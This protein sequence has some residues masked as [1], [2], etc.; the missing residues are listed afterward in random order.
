MERL[1]IRDTK[2]PPTSFEH[3]T[4]THWERTTP[5]PGGWDLGGGALWQFATLGVTAAG[6]DSSGWVKGGSSNYQY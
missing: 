3:W 6:A 2:R 4:G 5:V 1:K